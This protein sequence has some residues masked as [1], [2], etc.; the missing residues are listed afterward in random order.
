MIAKAKT[1]V[2]WLFCSELPPKTQTGLAAWRGRNV[3]LW[4]QLLS[5]QLLGS[6]VTWW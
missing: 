1:I 4:L 2:L 3:S 6:G 5:L